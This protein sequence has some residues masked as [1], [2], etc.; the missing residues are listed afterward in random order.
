MY[1]PTHHLQH[2]YI[3]ILSAHSERDVSQKREKDKKVK[4]NPITYLNFTSLK[5]LNKK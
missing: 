4:T 3:D 5:K 2:E 1:T